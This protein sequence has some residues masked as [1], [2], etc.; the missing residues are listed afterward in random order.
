MER[1]SSTQRERFS[2][3]DLQIENVRC[4]KCPMCDGSDFEHFYLRV[5][6]I[7]F[8]CKNR[9]FFSKKPEVFSKIGKDSKFE[10]K[11][12]SKDIV[13]KIC[14]FLFPHLHWLFSTQSEIYIWKNYQNL[15]RI[16]FSREKKR[17]HL[18]RRYL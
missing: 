9:R 12:A 11:W 1:K 16:V 14:F 18:S 2:Y 4:W 10:V 13:S 6:A 7:C 17:F 5:T 15:P 3:V 8:F